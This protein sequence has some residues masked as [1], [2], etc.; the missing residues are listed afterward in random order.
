VCSENLVMKLCSSNL[1]LEIIFWKFWKTCSR[2][3]S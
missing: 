3:F 1:I 2:K